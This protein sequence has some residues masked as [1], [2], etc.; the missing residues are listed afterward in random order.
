MRLPRP[1][2]TRRLPSPCARPAIDPTRVCGKFREFDIE[3][4]DV[5]IGKPGTGEMG[6]KV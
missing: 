1:I 2:R 4:V 6:G 5:L 3:C